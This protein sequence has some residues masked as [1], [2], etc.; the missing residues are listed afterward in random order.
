MG[1]EHLT[2]TPISQG[3]DRNG[4]WAASFAWWLQ[5]VLKKDYSFAD[6]L[7]M[8]KKWTNYKGGENADGFGAMTDIGV[9]FMFNDMRFRIVGE[10]SDSGKL[11]VKRANELLNISPVLIAYYEPAVDGYHMNVLVS[12]V[13]SENLKDDMFVMDPANESFQVRKLDY[14]KR[15]NKAIYLGYYLR[16]A[17]SDQPFIPYELN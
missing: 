6:V 1:L 11:V 12:Q 2:T 15:Y 13:N 16:Q 4:C 9:R 10:H 14:Y 5:A 8:Y 7:Q 3:A 17:P